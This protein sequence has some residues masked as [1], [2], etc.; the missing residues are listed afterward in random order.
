MEEGFHLGLQIHSSHRLC[1]PVGHSRHPKY[2]RSVPRFLRYLYRSHRRRKIRPRAHPVPELV[3]VVLQR[4]FE[5]LEGLPVDS[6]GSV[7]GLD[8]A[9]R[10]PDHLLRDRKWFR[11]RLG[12][13]FLLPWQLPVAQARIGLFPS[14]D[15]RYRASSLVRNSPPL[16]APPRY[17]APCGS[18]RLEVSLLRPTQP[19]ASSRAVSGSQLPT[20]HAGA[21]TGLAPPIRRMPPGQQ[22]GSPQACPESFCFLGFGIVSV[23]L[24]ASSAVRLRSPSRLTPDALLSAVSATFTT[25][26]MGAGAACGGLEPPPARRFRGADPHRQRSIASGFPIYIGLPSAFVAQQNSGL[27]TSN[28]ADEMVCRLRRGVGFTGRGLADRGAH[29]LRCERIRAG[30]ECARV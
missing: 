30:S 27:R 28:R 26:A 24:D 22:A 12:R 20:F 16:L 25:P 19:S 11:S 29:P 2:S 7:V 14:L 17:S 18:S 5:L 8:P 1:D 15:P 21:C 13:R 9:I 4:L 6:L 10:L 23:P 3:Q